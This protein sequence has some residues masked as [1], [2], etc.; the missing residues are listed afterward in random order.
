MTDLTGAV[1][2]M[3]AVLR[4]EADVLRRGA[5]SDLDPLERRKRKAW[6][7]LQSARP[8]ERWPDLTDLRLLAERNAMLLLAA[9]AGIEAAQSLRE[10][11]KTGPAPL[12]TYGADG[13]KSTLSRTMNSRQNSRSV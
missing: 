3:E 10:R 6:A 4:E 5:L 9:R 7:A 2:R 12:L 11:L 8:S 1:A 13:R